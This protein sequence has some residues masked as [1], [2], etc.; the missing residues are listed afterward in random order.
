MRYLSFFHIFKF[1]N[2]FNNF[3]NFKIDCTFPFLYNNV[4]YDTCTNIDR[5]FYWCSIGSVYANMF[6]KCTSQCPE[7]AR[8]LV[9]T[10]SGQLH[11]SCQP[12]GSTFTQ[13]L[14]PNQT[15]INTILSLHNNARSK[16]SPTASSMSSLRWD[17]RLARI[18]Q[19]RSDQCIF[20][21]DCANCRRVLNLGK[22]VYVGQNAFSQSGGS[23]DWTGAINAFLSELQYF[24]YG[25][26]N[27]QGNFCF[28]DFKISITCMKATRDVI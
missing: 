17:V 26:S 12:R 25:G 27:S 11:T 14:F 28:N 9:A 5:G 4:W 8:I 10:D 22:S 21:H 13:S 24:S 16:V 19:S 18:A 6:A 3:Y 23:F 20:A 7:L 1:L 2:F 15:S